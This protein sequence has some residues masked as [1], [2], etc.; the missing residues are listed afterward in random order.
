MSKYE[1]VKYYF[2]NNLWKIN[3]VKDAVIKGW[4]T[5]AEFEEITGQPY[6]EE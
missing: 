2:D 1:R 6:E 3:R 5:E 4:I